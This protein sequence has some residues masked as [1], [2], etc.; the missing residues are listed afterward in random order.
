M[1][2]VSG[3]TSLGEIAPRRSGSKLYSHNHDPAYDFLLYSGPLDALGAADALLGHP[4][5]SS[6]SSRSDRP[7]ASSTSSRTSTGRMSRSTGSARTPI[8]TASADEVFDPGGLVAENT[9]RAS[10]VPREGRFADD[11]APGRRLRVRDGAVRR[12]GHRLRDSSPRRASKATTPCIEQDNAPGGPSTRIRRVRRRSR[13]IFRA[14]SATRAC[15]TVARPE[16]DSGDRP[17]HRPGPLAPPRE[18]SAAQY[19]LGL[20][21]GRAPSTSRALRRARVEGEAVFG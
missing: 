8:R 6:T 15:T 1:P 17:G 20:R 19:L 5:A 12:R 9:H 16:S 4:Q 13:S 7:R 11:R 14:T 2:P 21:G 3:G 10:A 18:A